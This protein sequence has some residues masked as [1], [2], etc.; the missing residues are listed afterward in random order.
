MHT[1]SVTLLERLR[2]PTDQDAW[3]RF[4]RL[5]TPLLIYWGRKCGL[6]TADAAD[7]VQDVL[8]SLFQKL[9][10]FCYQRGKSFRSWLRAVT[11]NQWRDRLR[12]LQSRP[13]PGGEALLAA[14]ASPDD[15]AELEDNEYRERLVSV[16]LRLVQGDFDPKTWQAFW[17]FA[18]E[19]RPASEVARE[20]SM[21]PVT[22]YGAKFRIVNRLR[23]ELQ[24]LL[25]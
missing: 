15:I 7:L 6:Q 24:G 8:S 5:Y 12:W 9:P 21:T 19:G 11:L 14:V 13:L 3:S 4:V 2:D 17:Q 1:T 22:V 23:Q 10:G 16:A 25:E 18:V 20:L